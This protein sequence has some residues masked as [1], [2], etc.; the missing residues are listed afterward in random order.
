MAELKAKG[1][2]VAPSLRGIY[3]F[4]GGIGGPIV[5]SRVWFFHS[6]RRWGAANY[7]A[8]QFFDNG[9]PAF[10]R[11]KLQG[12][13][14]RLTI[15]VNPK[16]KLS[17]MYDALPKYRDFFGSETG[18]ARRIGDKTPARQTLSDIV[19]R[20]ALKR[21]RD[22]SRQKRSQTLSSRPFELNA[23]GIVGQSPGSMTA[24][25]RPA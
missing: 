25:N 24:R 7:I 13:T 21:D 10:D 4:N 22:S 16:N 12:Y 14:T 23:D 1:L 6:T 17:V 20:I 3:D 5:K 8:N 19:V 15:Q 18:G 9:D 11:S 2:T